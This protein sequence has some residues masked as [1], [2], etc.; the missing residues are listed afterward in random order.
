MAQK[1]DETRSTPAPD[2]GE[3]GEK[4]DGWR[5][6]PATSSPS[7]RSGAHSNDEASGIVDPAAPRSSPG[8]NP[9]PL[10]EQVTPT[11]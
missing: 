7:R 1:P 5:E 8:K 11:P 6:E 9:G 2:L 4:R 10:E 3:P